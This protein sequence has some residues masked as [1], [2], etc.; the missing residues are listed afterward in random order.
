[1]A[2]DNQAMSLVSAVYEYTKL[3][4]STH[5]INL[6]QNY[7]WAATGEL[8]SDG[9]TLLNITF[10]SEGSAQAVACQVNKLVAVELGSAAMSYANAELF[11]VGEFTFSMDTT[12]CRYCLEA[13]SIMV[14]GPDDG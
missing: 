7:A 10:A 13:H 9:I 6:L 8:V 5:I 3:Q 2:I 12:Q 4:L 11:M 14:H 1:M